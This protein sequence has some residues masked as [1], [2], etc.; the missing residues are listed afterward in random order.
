MSFGDFTELEVVGFRELSRRGFL[1]GVVTVGAAGLAMPAIGLIEACGGTSSGT[2]EGNDLLSKV[3]KAGVI[4]IGLANDPPAS[5]MNPDGSVSG[6]GPATVQK[7]MAKLGVPKVHGIVA[8]FGDLVPG[9]QAGRWDMI[10]G[11]ISV[12]KA[13]CAI[14]QYTD[15]FEFNGMEI[16]WYPNV[17]SQAPT[18][19]G[20]VGKRGLIV[21][22]NAGSAYIA[23]AKNLG[24][25]DSK[26]QQ[27]PD[28]AALLEALKSKRI[29]VIISDTGSL[30]LTADQQ[31][32]YPFQHLDYPPDGPFIAG[33]LAFR[34]SDKTLFDAFQAEFKKMKDSGEFDQISAQFQFP[35]L[36]ADKKNLGP[37]EVCAK[38]V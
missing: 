32:K 1:R 17:V 29:Q 19:I 26:I 20:D 15:P 23:I 2:N 22:F 37:D 4:N 21:G 30:L 10:G 35:P 18:S 28:T 9:L 6:Q 12:T 5:I 34:K 33:A 13:R 36:P 24:V 14:V 25:Q 16:A 8:T 27:F 31:A 11:V 3:K 7:I 38:V